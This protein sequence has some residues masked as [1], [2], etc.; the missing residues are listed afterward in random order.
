MKFF[1][2]CKQ[3]IAKIALV[4]RTTFEGHVDQYSGPLPM[5]PADVFRKP[6]LFV[7]TE[8]ALEIPR[9]VSS[10]VDYWIFF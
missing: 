8:T 1:F 6:I 5:L 4:S 2:S 10:Y 3:Q 9:N 7:V